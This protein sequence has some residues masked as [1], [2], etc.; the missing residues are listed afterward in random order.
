MDKA[1]ALLQIARVGYDVGFG[2]KKHFA[3]Y[4]LIE[5]SPGWLA[6]FSLIGGLWALFVPAMESKHLGALF[7]V[8]SFVTFYVNQYVPDKD[9]YQAAGKALVTIYHQLAALSAKTASLPD[10]SDF[11]AAFD[12]SSRLRDG[13]IELGITKQIFAS[14]W[15]AHFKFFFQ[16]QHDWIDAQLRFRLFKDKI[17]A[18]LY[19]VI[20]AALI[21]C[22][23]TYIYRWSCL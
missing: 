21:G 11:Q 10:G 14:D 2:S 9:K 19:A 13:A 18:G 8:F 4:D 20:L 5:K 22:A 16:T 23:V 15:Y 6:F 3:T 1:T 17:P 12:E 7:I